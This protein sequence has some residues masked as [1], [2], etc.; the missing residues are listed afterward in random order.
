MNKLEKGLLIAIEG[1]DGSGKS[2]L[3]RNLSEKLSN[4]G[5]QTLLTKEPGATEFG[6]NVRQVINYA[7]EKVSDLSEFLL[8]SADRAEHFEKIVIPALNQKKIVI[9]DRM[10]DS[11]VAYQGYGRG[12]DVKFIKL[13]SKQAMKDIEPD[14]IFY[15]DL[16]YKVAME[17]IAARKEKKTIFEQE[18]KEFFERVARGFEET[19][20]KKDNVIRLDGNLNEE[21][22]MESAFTQ[23][24]KFIEKH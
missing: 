15:V 17:R 6:K 11:S 22:L 24:Q 1:I 2:T 5:Y 12:I 14:L 3:A 23:V 9:S 13:V 8:F 10:A 19:F 4:Q 16:D 21:K 18:Q 20:S 7:P